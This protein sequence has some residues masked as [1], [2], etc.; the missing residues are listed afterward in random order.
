MKPSGSPAISIH[1]EGG[2]GGSAESLSGVGSEEAGEISRRISEARN[3]VIATA[4]EYCTQKVGYFIRA[5]SG[6]SRKAALLADDLYL[7]NY[8]AKMVDSDRCS[9]E[10]VSE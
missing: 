8:E 6:K 7:A 4:E 5:F 3:G 9:P 1:P 10:P 2:R